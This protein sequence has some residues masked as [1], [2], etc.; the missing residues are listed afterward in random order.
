[1]EKIFCPVHPSLSSYKTMITPM[2]GQLINTIWSPQLCKGMYNS[3][4]HCLPFDSGHCWS[5]NKAISLPGTWLATIKLLSGSHASKHAFQVNALHQYLLGSLLLSSWF[6]APVF[7]SSHRKAKLNTEVQTLHHK[8]FCQVI[9]MNISRTAC[10]W[11][12]VI[13]SW[14]NKTGS[15]G[16][17]WCG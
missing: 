5:L 12:L 6:V 10:W 11:G 2:L 17:A 16:I 15:S 8:L 14:L 4:Y 9:E 7:S 3:P 1:M 13:S